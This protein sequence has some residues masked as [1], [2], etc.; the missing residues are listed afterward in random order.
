MPAKRQST[1]IELMV[2]LMRIAPH[3]L[4]GDKP[5]REPHHAQQQNGDR[6]QLN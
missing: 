1:A 5:P 6:E 3:N 4:T 2:A